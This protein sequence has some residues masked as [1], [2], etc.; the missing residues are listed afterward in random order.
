MIDSYFYKITEKLNLNLRKKVPQ[1]LQTEAAECGLASLAMICHYYG[2]QIDLFNLRQRFGLSS[3]GATLKTLVAVASSLKLKT[4]P[5]SLDIDEI[6]ALKTPCVLHWDMNHFVVLAAVRGG[7]II[8]HDPAFGRRVLGLREISQHFT[9]IALEIWPDCEFS[10]ATEKSRIRFRTLLSNIY[11]LKSALIKILCLSIVIEAINLLMPVGTQLVMD[12]VILAGDHD[13]LAVI[14]IGLL[15]SILLRTGVAIFRTWTSI[16]MGAVINVQWKAGV[17]DHLIKLPLTYFEKRKLGDIHSRFGSLETIQ[18]TFTTNIVNSIIDCIM[19]AGVFVMMLLYGGCLVWVCLG[20]TAVYVLLRLGTYRHYRQVSEEQLVKGAKADSHFMETLYSISTLKSLGIAEIRAQ[21]LLNLNI[22]TTNAGIK[23]TK[24]DMMFGGINSFI[25]ACDQI[26]VLWLGASL[27]IDNQISLGMFIAFNAYRGQFSEQTG[28]LTNMLVQLRML[29]LHN[30]RI[31]DIVLSEPEMQMPSQRLFSFGKATSFEVRNLI[32]QYDSLSKPVI[33]NLNISIKSGESVAIIGPSG[34]GKTTLM[35]LMSGLLKPTGGTLLIDG[36]DIHAIGVN[37]YRQSISCV[38]QD[39]KLLSGSIAENIAG[40][41]LTPDYEWI[42]ICA[43]NCNIHNDILKMP[44]GYETLVG[45]LGGSLSGGQKQ[46]L[47]IARALYRRP[48]ILFLDEATSHL[49]L[50]NEA[51]INTA[52][53]SL[54]I[55]RVIIAHRPSTIAS[56]GRII[57]L[58]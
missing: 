30:E 2:L 19:S 44:M 40:F 18:T 25:G 35:K 7:R 1:V 34:I 50:D 41:D 10:P 32:Y 8:I 14:C 6:N 52:I 29:S 57:T 11:G 23:Q 46:R 33:N 4:R 15:F 16:V 26:L 13:L 36:L 45:E 53:S 55:T 54:D 51:L 9:G 27:V 5:L 22:D 21:S 24:L 12:H 56:A 47:L 17:F 31:S 20:F 48:N 42:K 3:Q 38:L 37:N 43:L 58:T 39:D 28:N 49:D